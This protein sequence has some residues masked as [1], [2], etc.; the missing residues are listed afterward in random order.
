MREHEGE[1]HVADAV[2]DWRDTCLGH[3]GHICCMLPTEVSMVEPQNHLALQL[4][5]F[6]VFEP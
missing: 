6:V 4:A 5:S 1:D 3:G 2:A